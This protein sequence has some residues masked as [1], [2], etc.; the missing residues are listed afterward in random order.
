ML[1]FIGGSFTPV[2]NMS[3]VM[4]QIGGLSPNGAAMSAYLDVLQGASIADVAESS[5]G[6]ASAYRCFVGCGLVCFSEKGGSSVTGIILTK[7][8]LFVRK[9]GAIHHYGSNLHDVC[10]FCWKRKR[11]ENYGTCF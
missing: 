11:K 2:G 9:P 10:V 7:F 3:E 8:R 1:A 4:A 5:L 6:I